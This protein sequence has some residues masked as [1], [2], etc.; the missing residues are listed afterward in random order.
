MVVVVC[1]DNDVDLRCTIQ[2]ALNWYLILDTEKSAKTYKTGKTHTTEKPLSGG[3]DPK[4]VVPQTNY[5][6]LTIMGSQL[7]S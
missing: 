2:E 4:P 3:H 1:D 7:L 5:H 6:T